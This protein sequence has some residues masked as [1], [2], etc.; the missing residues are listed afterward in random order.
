MIQPLTMPDPILRRAAEGDRDAVAVLLQRHGPLVWS[1]C[2][3]LA[4][5]PEDCYQEVWEKVIR[6]LPTFDPRGTATLSTW[7]AT[8]THRHLVDRYRRRV[9]RGEVLPLGDLPS[10][11]DPE[12]G[13]DE[14]RR[15]ARLDSALQRLPA[16][17][18]RV[19]VMHHLEDLP[20]EQIAADEDVAVGT[21]KSRL[22]RGRARLLE[23]LGGR[24]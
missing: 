16:D 20:L 15:V 2:R 22:H 6:A 12:G 24:R 1:L 13:L 23:L 10:A 5:D 19:I 4:P 9:V 14:K 3:R 8:I 18:R 21:V 7:I 17:Q 11:S